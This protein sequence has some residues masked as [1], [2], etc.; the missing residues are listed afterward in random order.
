MANY[1]NLLG[2]KKDAS[3]GEIADAFQR[4]NLKYGPESSSYN[5][6]LF[7]KIKTA[8][9][10]LHNPDK[11]AE[12]DLSS[13]EEEQKTSNSSRNPQPS[14]QIN[15]NVVIC[16]ECNTEQMASFVVYDD[17]TCEKCGKAFE[18]EIFIVRRQPKQTKARRGGGLYNY[19]FQ[20]NRRPG[21][22][23]ETL[24]VQSSDSSL[25]N[26]LHN[27]KVCLIKRSSGEK[28]LLINYHDGSIY[29]LYFEEKKSW[30]DN[31]GENVVT[32]LVIILSLFFSCF[33]GGWLVN[34][35]LWWLL[36]SFN[37]WLHG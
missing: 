21:G 9:D 31:L 32:I 25:I 16:P 10:V 5:E 29:R 17:L 6:E 8:Y 23:G 20:V 28:S 12:Y 1:Y 37:N 4:L 36:N 15:Q 35:L 34:G 24:S 14:P 3:F 26:I 11:R 27:H 13:S 18:A 7:R 22:A 30:L 2:V 33:L 19:E